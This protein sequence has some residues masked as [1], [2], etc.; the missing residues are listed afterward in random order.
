MSVEKLSISLDA[1]LAG[2]VRA[3]AEES[4]VSVSTWFAEAAAAR[5]RQ[6]NLQLA[7]ATSYPEVDNLSDSELEAIITQARQSSILTS[8][9][10][11]AA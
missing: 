11:R 3:A 10:R 4:H 8:P 5:V 7:I 9:L 1:E 6:R 2:S